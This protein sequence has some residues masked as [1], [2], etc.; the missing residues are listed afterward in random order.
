MQTEHGAA[1]TGVGRRLA[2][3][4]APFKEGMGGVERMRLSV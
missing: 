3:T 2:N 4:T 1:S